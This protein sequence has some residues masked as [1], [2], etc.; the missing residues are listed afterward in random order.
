M[1]CLY[2]VVFM[3]Y[4][5]CIDIDECEEAA[6]SDSNICV[7]NSN[8]NNSPGSFSCVC[9]EGYKLVNGSCQRKK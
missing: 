4:V 5:L 6:R 7:E 3:S 2:H 9:F 1:T 8:C